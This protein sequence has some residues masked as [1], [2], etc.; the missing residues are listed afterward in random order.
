[1]HHNNLDRLCRL[2]HARAKKRLFQPAH[3]HPVSIAQ[4]DRACTDRCFR[5]LCA[6]HGTGPFSASYI[7]STVGITGEAFRSRKTSTGG[8]RQCIITMLI[9]NRILSQV[10]LVA[11]RGDGGAPTMGRLPPLC[12]RGLGSAT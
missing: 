3:S 1:V 4:R 12:G 5:K 11:L 9:A 10:K 8:A 6:S 2:G 7:S